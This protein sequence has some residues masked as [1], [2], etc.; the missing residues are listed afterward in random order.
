MINT[1]KVHC[2]R[3]DIQ[4]FGFDLFE[5]LSEVEL[6]KEFSKMPSAK[7]EVEE[8]LIKTGANFKLFKGYTAETLPD[9][10]RYAKTHGISADFIFIDG[11]HAIKTITSDWENVRQLINNKTVVVFDDYYRNNE[12]EIQGYGCNAII[13]LMDRNIY[14][15]S[16]LL[17]EDSFTKPWGVLNVRLAKVMLRTNM[18]P[19]N[20]R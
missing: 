19:R 3:K 14:E 9:F 4:Y 6:R 2:R 5:D 12:P 18:L 20:A 16:I 8:K 15:P 10:V 17:P 1:A 13:D 11:G 7:Q